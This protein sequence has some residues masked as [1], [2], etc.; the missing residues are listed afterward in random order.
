MRC[1]GRARGATG[2]SPQPGSSQ[3]GRGEAEGSGG[4]GPVNGA[5]PAVPGG[6]GRPGEPGPGALGFG[7]LGSPSPGA[8]Q[9]WGLRPAPPGGGGPGAHLA[10][11]S[12]P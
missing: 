1:P 8:R 3:H 11:N 6:S 12:P 9:R 7:A 5:V 10:R 4:T 2:G